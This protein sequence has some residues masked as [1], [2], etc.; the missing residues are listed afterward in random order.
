MTKKEILNI[1]S[2][3]GIYLLHNISN[4]KYYV[5]Q[6]INLKKRLLH[7]LSN[8][9]T[10][11]YDAP[12]YKAIHKYGIENFSI[13]ILYTTDNKNFTE[14]KKTIRFIRKKNIL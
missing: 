9:N 7:H 3:P 13:K 6:A 5:G 10:M 11:R 4:N 8:L 1:T 14:V 2:N 12:I